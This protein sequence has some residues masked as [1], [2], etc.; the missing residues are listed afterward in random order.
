MRSPSNRT[1]R[2]SKA[3]CVPF[4]NKKIIKG[5]VI[6]SQQKCL[7]GN[8]SRAHL[9]WSASRFLMS[10][11]CWPLGS[12]TCWVQWST[13][14]ISTVSRW[15]GELDRPW[16][17]D[18]SKFSYSTPPTTATTKT[19]EYL[20]TDLI[21]IYLSKNVLIFCCDTFSSQSSELMGLMQTF[22]AKACQDASYGGV[23]NIPCVS[24]VENW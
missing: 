23:W 7:M 6:C 24:I 8:T 4:A 15:C 18:N 11:H 10:S 2:R 14:P 21:Q 12:W 13:L 9:E 5:K 22:Q 20:I 1:M 16:W 3:Q 17:P 19:K